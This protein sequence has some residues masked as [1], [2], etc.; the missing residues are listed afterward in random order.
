[1]IRKYLMVRRLRSVGRLGVVWLRPVGGGGTILTG[2]LSLAV[3]VDVGLVAIVVVC[4][5][6]HLRRVIVLLR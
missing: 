6:I 2:E 3:V 5:V 1:M 4:H